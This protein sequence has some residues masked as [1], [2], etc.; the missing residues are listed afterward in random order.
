MRSRKRRSETPGATWWAKVAR[1]Y[2]LD[3][4]ELAKRTGC[5]HED[6]RH[7][8]RGYMFPGCRE[9]RVKLERVFREEYKRRSGKK[10]GA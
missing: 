1:M 5:D 4:P 2:D 3:V 10:E 6:V 7:V 9:V 8:L